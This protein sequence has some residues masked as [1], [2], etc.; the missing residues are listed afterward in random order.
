MKLPIKELLIFIIFIP[1]IQFAIAHVNPYY[2]S[3]VEMIKADT[4]FN[5]GHMRYVCSAGYVTNEDFE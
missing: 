2:E 5:H 3:Y 1:C 4:H